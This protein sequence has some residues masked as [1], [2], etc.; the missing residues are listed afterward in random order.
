MPWDVKD[1][2][3]LAPD[4]VEFLA[5]FAAMVM[6]FIVLVILGRWWAN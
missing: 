4:F 2:G 5:A 6:S 3:F 1:V